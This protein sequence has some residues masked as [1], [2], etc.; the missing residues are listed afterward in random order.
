[1]GGSNSGRRNGKPCTDDMRSLDIR[2]V[3]RKGLLKE[4][5]T[6]GWSWFRHSETIAGILISV[7]DDRVQL[8]YSQS[9]RGAPWTDCMNEIQLTWTAC[10][11]GGQRPWWTCP[12]CNRRTA[13]L[14]SGRCRYAC[15]QCFQL[16]YKCQRETEKDLA[17][18]RANGI[19]QRLGW[20]PGIA[21]PPGGK[22]K[23]MRWTTYFRLVNQHN[24]HLSQAMAA[25]RMSLDRFR[26]QQNTIT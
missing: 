23:G 1:M 16:A 14:Y 6:F 9:W 19:R 7:L 11:F 18:R 22:P 10:H 4:G 21:N 3:Y 17:A 5:N 25:I 12:T 20:E 8:R 13:L 26:K 24:A 15:R 2:H